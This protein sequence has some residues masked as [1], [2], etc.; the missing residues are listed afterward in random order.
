MRQ[1]WL[2]AVTTS[3]VL[4]CTAGLSAQGGSAP[5][6]RPFERLFTPLPAPRPTPSLAPRWFRPPALPASPGRC[7]AAVLPADTR[8]IRRISIAPP[9]SRQLTIR[10]AIKPG[11]R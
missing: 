4:A 5:S 9:A 6:P 1:R 10:D 8:I 7:D 3:S 11:C 2:L